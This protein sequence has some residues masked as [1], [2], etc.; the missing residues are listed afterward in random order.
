MKII[1]N[2]MI[3]KTLHLSTCHISKET[4]KLWDRNLDCATATPIPYG[5]YMYAYDDFDETFEPE[6]EAI[7]KYARSRGCSY[8]RFDSDSETIEGLEEFC[9]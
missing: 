1:A 2:A 4:A 5:Y 6:I 9:W 3:E 7:C 8:I